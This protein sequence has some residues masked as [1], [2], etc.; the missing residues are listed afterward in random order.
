MEPLGPELVAEG[1]FY[2]RRRPKESPL[3][4]CLSRHF[5][6]FLEVYEERYQPRYGFLRPIIP[7]VVNKFFL[8]ADLKQG[9]ARIRCDHCKHEF[10]LPY[11][12]RQRYFCPSCH[13]KKVQLFGELLRERLSLRDRTG[14]SLICTP[15][16]KRAHYRPRP[17][18][19]G[20]E[21]VLWPRS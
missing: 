16:A 18:S 19:D 3:W 21:S 12:C 14:V 20:S 9:F 13:Q 1:Q 8:C 15:A 6:M 7:E 11:S 5:D 10:I 2:R 17:R 4:Q